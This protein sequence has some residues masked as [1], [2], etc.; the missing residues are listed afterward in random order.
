MLQYVA[1]K[2]LIQ[3]SKSNLSNLYWYFHFPNIYRF[4]LPL[5]KS[6]HSRVLK[7]LVYIEY[8]VHASV[9]NYS[10]Q[11]LVIS[12]AFPT[13][14]HYPTFKHGTFAYVWKYQI[15]C[16]SPEWYTI[17]LGIWFC[18]LMITIGSLLHDIG[19]FGVEWINGMINVVQ[20]CG[21]T[22]LHIYTIVY[23]T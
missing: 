4:L 23:I 12:D 9:W 14:L 1:R 2:I 10:L 17:R 6:F 16:S 3:L 5:P 15:I 8:L 7:F 20:K 13:I 21:S 22:Q 18:V 19:F 11:T